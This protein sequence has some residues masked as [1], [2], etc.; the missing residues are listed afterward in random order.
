MRVPSFK[1]GKWQVQMPCLQL[2]TVHAHL[3]RTPWATVLFLSL[4]NPAKTG[5]G[6]STS[7]ICSK[8]MSLPL[9]VCTSASAPS[10]PACETPSVLRQDA[11][12]RVRHQSKLPSSMTK[13]PPTLGYQAMM[14]H[15][16]LP[17]PKQTPLLPKKALPCSKHTLSHNVT[18]CLLVI[19]PSRDSDRCCFLMHLVQRGGPTIYPFNTWTTQRSFYLPGVILHGQCHTQPV[20]QRHLHKISLQKAVLVLTLIWSQRKENIT[21]K[22]TLP[23]SEDGH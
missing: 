17:V 21:E 4:Q 12:E 13:G 19:L 15:Q 18:L 9:V 14:Q 23:N 10:L 7:D 1:Y 20:F 22:Y 5:Q 11:K 16:I 2:R 6:N 3:L 8:T